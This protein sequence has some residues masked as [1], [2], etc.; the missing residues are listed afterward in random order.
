[1]HSKGDK[2]EKEVGLA[3]DG[4]YRPIEKEVGEGLLV[5]VGWVAVMPSF[6]IG[7]TA[8]GEIWGLLG[9]G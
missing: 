5:L 6:G 3:A 1:M 4:M 9:E 7:D 2:D 8:A